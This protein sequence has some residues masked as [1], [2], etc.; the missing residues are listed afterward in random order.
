MKILIP[1]SWR[2]R[3]DRYRLKATKCKKCGRVAYPRS[4]V[5]RFC[6]SQDVEEIEL[7]NEKAK[8][9]TWTIIYNTM[10]GFE[11]RKPLIVGIVE[12][13][14]SK[15][16]LTAII[17]DVLPEELTKGMLLEPVLRRITDEEANLIHYGISY[18][19]VLKKVE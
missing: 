18:R 12:T 15:A 10:D 4:R 13:V 5:C 9:L 7:I 6:G 11:E 19:P 14:E 17:T 2:T 3:I 8:L 16:R 1:P